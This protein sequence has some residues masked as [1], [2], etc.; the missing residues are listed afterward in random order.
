VRNRKTRSKRANAEREQDGR[1]LLSLWRKLGWSAR[2]GVGFA[3]GAAAAAAILVNALFMQTGPHPAP[4]F[5]GGIL[6]A[7]AETTST[8]VT[9][10]PRARP[11]EAGVIAAVPA[12]IES[13]AP[14]KA[15]PAASPRTPGEI[16][17]EVQ[18]E[19]ARRG[20]YEGTPDG[21]YGP[22]TDAAVRDFER[23]ASLKPSTEPNEALLRAIVHSNVKAGKA[24]P[25]LIPPAPVRAAPES[26]SKRIAAV[27]R[28]LSDYGYGQIKPSG[29]VDA[30]TKAA[31]E[32]FERER[33]L[34]VTGQVSDRVANE[35]SAL[36]G[37]SLD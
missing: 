24:G 21:F 19:L 36:T 16:V 3:V 12:R 11:P 34:P 22:K 8:V 5:R 23:A 7:A 20:F 9:T 29:V 18:R 30:E 6:P 28:A 33:K 15:E 2:D 31:I 27:Q 32:K 13:P 25:P 14:A 10:L 26:A 17:G 1:S 37:R 4:I 35:L